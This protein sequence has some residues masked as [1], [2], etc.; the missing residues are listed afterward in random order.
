MGNKDN[1]ITLVDA[2]ELSTFLEDTFLD[3]IDLDV[4]F[5][6]FG[7]LEGYFKNHQIRITFVPDEGYLILSTSDMTGDTL[8]TLAA[9]LKQVMNEDPIAK[10]KLVS[11]GDE[12]LSIEWDVKNPEKRVYELVNT[13][14]FAY[15]KVYDLELLGDR[16]RD[17]YHIGSSQLAN[18]KKVRI[19]GLD[20]GC[21][22]P[23]SVVNISEGKLYLM[24]SGMHTY[25]AELQEKMIH[26]LM[27]KRDLTEE[28]LGAEYLIYQTRRFGVELDEPDVD[29]HI[30]PTPS[31]LFFMNFYAWHFEEVLS[32][33]ERYALAVAI[34]KGED[35]SA[36]LPS[37]SWLDHYNKE[38]DDDTTANQKRIGSFK[39]TTDIQ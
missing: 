1:N 5:C 28:L 26:G 7:R 13:S 21:I 34:K 15:G 33:K 20:P 8:N 3:D 29:K 12:M 35:I 4:S 23:K 32:R 22:D 27:P 10:Y 39:N 17:D 37:G 38:H 25:I 31:Y 18:S 14:P 6:L 16:K 36:F 2:L 30:A 19:P 24:I 9:S 11:D